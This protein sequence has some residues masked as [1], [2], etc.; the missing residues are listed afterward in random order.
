[1]NPNYTKLEL[2]GKNRGFKFGLSFLSNVLDHLD[3]S[4]A[5]L[6]EAMQKNPFKVLPVMIF[7]AHK[8]NELKARREIDFVLED[9]YDWIDDAGGVAGQ[10]VKEFIAAWT[11]SMNKDVPILEDSDEPSS[12]EPKKKL[13]GQTT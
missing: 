9:V 8:S 6:G 7:E 12:D 5:D 3:I 13:T 2:G 4:I 1:M 11:L 10:P